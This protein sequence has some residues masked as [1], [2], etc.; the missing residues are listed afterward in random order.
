MSKSTI[1]YTLKWN[2]ALVSCERNTKMTGKQLWWMTWIIFL[3]HQLAR[4]RTPS[5][6][7][8]V[9][10]SIP[11][12]LMPWACM[13]ANVTSSI[14]FIVTADKGN[15]MNSEVYRATNYSQIQPNA[16]KP[17][18]RCITVQMDNDPEVYIKINPRHFKSKKLNGTRSITRAESNLA[19]FTRWRRNWR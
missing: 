6:R 3:S 8:G 17:I 5:S 15:R 7:R 10:P 4:S 16:S 12:R 19:G 1:W 13:A 2:D 18:G 9:I 14:V 11:P